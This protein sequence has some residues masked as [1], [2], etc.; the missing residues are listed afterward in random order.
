MN[1]LEKQ[2]EN[3]IREYPNLICAELRRMPRGRFGQTGVCLKQEKMPDGISR[4]DLAFVTDKTVFLVELKRD[5]VD[6]D[7]LQ[8]FAR[9]RAEFLKQYPNHEIRGFLVGMR[10]PDEATIRNLIGTEPVDILL[11]EDH[12]PHPRRMTECPE[13]GAGVRSDKDFCPYCKAALR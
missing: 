11:F 13:C 12:L 2:Y 3:V 10:C 4:I 6:C 1:D 9:Y 7:T 8:Q 5:V